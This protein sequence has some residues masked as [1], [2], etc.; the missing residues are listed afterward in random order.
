MNPTIRQKIAE[1]DIC[2][3]E[4]GKLTAQSHHDEFL[5]RL[6]ASTR[7]DEIKAWRWDDTTVGH[8][9]RLQWYAQSRHYANTWP[10]TEH[11][12]IT[13]DNQLSGRLMTSCTEHE[14][15]LIDISILPEYQNQGIGTA[16]IE[17]LQTL[18]RT[19][20]RVIQLT[21]NRTSSAVRLY[22]RLGFVIRREDELHYQIQWT[23][24]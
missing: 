4:L 15:L 8:F 19:S 17:E 13:Y 22:R 14:I 3:S 23:S 21:V 20:E 7:L 18:A 1:G 6:Y 5:Y 9:L 11:Y 12:I 24:L 10:D 16:L 2:L